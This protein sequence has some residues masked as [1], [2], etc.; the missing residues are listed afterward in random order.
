MKFYNEKEQ[1]YLETDT[2]GVGLRTGLLQVRDV[3]HCPKD[4]APENTIL[5]SITFTSKSLS[6]AKTYYSNTVYT[7]IP[8]LLLFQK[9]TLNHRPQA[10]SINIKKRYSDILKVAEHSIQIHQYKIHI[11]HK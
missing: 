6:S 4:T 1:L 8:L 7:E 9:D 2:L 11:L 10:T 5:I 3:M